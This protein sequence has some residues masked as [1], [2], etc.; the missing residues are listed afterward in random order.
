[1]GYGARALEALKSFYSGEL[2]NLDEV[3]EEDGFE[4]L[5]DVA[6]VEKVSRGPFTSYLL[7]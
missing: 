3:M 5:A 2:T 6:K 4:T 1:M 7:S